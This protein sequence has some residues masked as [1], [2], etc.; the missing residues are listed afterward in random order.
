MIFSPTPDKLLPTGTLVRVN[1]GLLY[2]MAGS[3]GKYGDGVI[4]AFDIATDVVYDVYDI[5]TNGGDGYNPQAALVQADNGELYSN[6]SGGGAHYFGV[7]LSFND[8]TYQE[9]V[10]SSFGN[11]NGGLTKGPDGVYPY[12]S[13]IQASHGLIYGM[14]ESGG[15][16]GLGTI[17]SYNIVTDTEINIHSF[18]GVDGSAPYGDLLEVDSVATGAKQ[19]TM[20]SGQLTVYPNPTSNQLTVESGQWTVNGITITNVFKQVYKK[21]ISGTH[22]NTNPN[23]N[24]VIDVSALPDGLYFITATAD[25]GT[26]TKKFIVSR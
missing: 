25:A 24:R 20:E 12:G 8:T 2:G 19:L 22:T 3:G 14:T 10:L 23:S 21:S 7:I 5:G 6:N 26:I 15:D 16:T 11:G 1:N 13:L 18:R 9:L 17:F 4:Y